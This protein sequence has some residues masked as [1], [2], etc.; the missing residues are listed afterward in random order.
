MAC[1]EAQRAHSSNFKIFRKEFFANVLLASA[2][3]SAVRHS[4]PPLDTVTFYIDYFVL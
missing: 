1:F 4:A 3:R 2:F